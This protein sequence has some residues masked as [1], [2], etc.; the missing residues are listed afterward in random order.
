MGNEAEGYKEPRKYSGQELGKIRV[1]GRVVACYH[2]KQYLTIFLISFLVFGCGF[3][4]EVYTSD[5]VIIYSGSYGYDVAYRVDGNYVYSGSYGYDVA[6]RIDGSNIYSGSY[7]YDVAY[8]IDGN[9]IY[10]GSY[11]Y[12][13]AFRVDGDR[14]YSGS[15]GY[16]VA[17]RIDRV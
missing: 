14:I 4:T 5:I 9:K 7:S 15:Y 2:K 13:V 16:N 10:S 3:D 1:E 17:Y 8:R 11:G 12:E 6:Y